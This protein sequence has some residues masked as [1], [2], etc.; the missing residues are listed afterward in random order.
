[1]YILQDGKSARVK[2]TPIRL[3]L[4]LPEQAGTIFVSS[5]YCTYINNV[6]F[7]LNQSNHPLTRKLEK[8]LIMQK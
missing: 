7:Q 5:I 3:M 2:G 1:M 4:T 6:L 8:Q